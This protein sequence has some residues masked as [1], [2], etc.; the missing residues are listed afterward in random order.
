MALRA[1]STCWRRSRY[2]FSSAALVARRSS[3][4]LAVAAAKYASSF[5]RAQISLWMVWRSRLCSLPMSDSMRAVS[6]AIFASVV[7][8]SSAIGWTEMMAADASAGRVERLRENAK[9]P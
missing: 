7:L 1:S 2:A 6:S 3:S 5:S 4:S 9:A 8:S